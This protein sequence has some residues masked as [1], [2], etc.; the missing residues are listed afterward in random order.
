MISR[1]NQFVH[2]STSY[3]QSSYTWQVVCSTLPLR[4]RLVLENVLPEYSLCAG[5][6]LG[7]TAGFSSLLVGCATTVNR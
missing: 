4:Y 6:V 2:S 5:H 7:T 1:Q 3:L